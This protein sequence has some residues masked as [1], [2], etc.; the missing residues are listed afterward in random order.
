MPA[1]WQT[2][3]ER[4]PIS[5][6]ATGFWRVLMQS[7]Q[8][9]IWKRACHRAVLSSHFLMSSLLGGLGIR[10]CGLV[11]YLLRLISM[12]PFSPRKIAPPIGPFSRSNRTSTPLA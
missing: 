6:L 12:F 5:T 10:L 1:R 4:W 3:T 8:F 11:V 7:S 9:W 2:L